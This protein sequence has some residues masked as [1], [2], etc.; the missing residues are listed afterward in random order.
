[1]RYKVWV[2]TYK[3]LPVGEEFERINPETGKH[4]FV[5]SYLY[6]EDFELEKIEKTEGIPKR[7]QLILKAEEK[8][9]KESGEIEPQRKFYN[10]YIETEEDKTNEEL[11]WEIS[12]W[13]REE[14]HKGVFISVRKVRES[15]E[16]RISKCRKCG[17]RLKP[18]KHEKYPNALQC[19]KCK[20]IY[21]ELSIDPSK[22]SQ[23]VK[24][25]LKKAKKA[26]EK[27]PFGLDEVV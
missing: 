21:I 4:E 7:W 2:A 18:V 3:E 12:G 26:G 1:M 15:T 24:E 27:L 9:Q 20:E 19:Q 22:F 11:E 16:R 13:L 17:G 10:L 8:M 6:S 23:R 5:F 25:G 14:G